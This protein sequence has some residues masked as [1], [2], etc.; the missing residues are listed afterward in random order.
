[1]LRRL[2]VA[3]IIDEVV[4]SRRSDAGASVGTYI[5]LATLNQVV[6]PCPKLAFSSWW[7]TAVGDRWLHLP[8][9]ALDHRRFWEAMDAIGAIKA[10]SGAGAVAVVG[11]PG[12]LSLGFPGLPCSVAVTVPFPAPAASNRACGSPA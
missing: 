1:M 9:G 3:E 10:G 5:T 4:G 12:S 7:D 6:D 8:S 11:G 2:H